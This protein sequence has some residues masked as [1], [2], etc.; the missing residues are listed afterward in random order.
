M[1]KEKSFVRY[2][3]FRGSRKPFYRFWRV[4]VKPHTRYY[5]K[6]YKGVLVP[7]KEDGSKL[8]HN[9]LE[10]DNP[11]FISRI[12]SVEGEVVYQYHK[13]INGMQTSF[14]EEIRRT[15]SINAGIFPTDDRG[16]SEFA[17]IF[18]DAAKKVDVLGI[19]D[20]SAEKYIL[21]C[22]DKQVIPIPFLSLYPGINTWTAVLRGQRVLVV[23]PFSESIKEQYYGTNR[24][25]LF[26]NPSIL[27]DYELITLQAVVSLAG[28]ETPFSS[29]REALLSM[30]S[31]VEAIADSFD[32]CLLGCGAY[33][34]PLGEMIFSNL[35]KKVVHVG[36]SLQLLFGIKGSFF[37]AFELTKPLINPFWIYPKPSETPAASSLVEGSCYW[38]PNTR[39]V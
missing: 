15:A 11:C 6:Y 9:L 2:A 4:L 22:A 32:I 5:P 33:G 19:W 23:H 35:H 20:V 39:E 10:K 26:N 8:I 13:I 34:L 36:G 18:F 27:P 28:E 7:S 17:R 12:G 16:L 30:Y 29:W 14:N 37:E 31:R 1:L 24:S 25:K 21:D 3:N 38:A